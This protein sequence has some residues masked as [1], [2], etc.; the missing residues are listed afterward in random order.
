ML[1]STQSQTHYNDPFISPLHHLEI[2]INHKLRQ[3]IYQQIKIIHP[4]IVLLQQ[5]PLDIQINNT[6]KEVIY[7]QITTTNI[8]IQLFIDRS[9]F[10]N[11]IRVTVYSPILGYTARPVGSLDIYTVYIGELEGINTALGLLIQNQHHSRI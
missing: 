10:D 6:H 8:G 5:E 2:I 4:F 7:T 1:Y 11:R 3:G 9:G